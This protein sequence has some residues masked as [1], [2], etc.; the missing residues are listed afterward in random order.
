MISIQLAFS[1]KSTEK[2]ACPGG[3]RELKV[4][5]SRLRKYIRDNGEKTALRIRCL[6]CVGC[7]QIHHELPDFFL[8]YKPYEACCFEKIIQSPHKNDIRADNSTLF[9][10]NRWFFI[11]IDYWLGCLHSIAL[12]FQ[13]NLTSVN[14]AS[15]DSLTVLEKIG[16]LV[17]DAD[18]WLSR[19]TKPVVNVNLWLQ[20]C[21]AFLSELSAFRLH[22]EDSIRRGCIMKDPKKRDEVA[23]SRFQLIAPL[24]SGDLD[25]AQVAEM[26][27]KICKTSGQEKW[28]SGLGFIDTAL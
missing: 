12:R 1:V 17:D 4:I 23:A 19:M 11:L 8:P 24:L 15:M 22:D 25:V 16:R 7:H 26:K 13:L 21:S 27:K 9:R 20:T 18:G 2:V 6:Q 3:G 28:A 14:P 10:W 5:G